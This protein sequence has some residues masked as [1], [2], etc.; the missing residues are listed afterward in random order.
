MSRMIGCLAFLLCHSI[1]VTSHA[2]TWSDVSGKFRVEAAFVGVVGNQVQLK[3]ADGRVINVPIAKLDAASI[4][5]A[6]RLHEQANA[7]VKPT[8][9]VAEEAAVATAESSAASLGQDPTIED[10]L[11]VLNRTRYADPAIFWDLLP[12]TYRRD[13]NELVRLFAKSCDAETWNAVVGL[14]RKVHRLFDEKED[15]IVGSPAVPAA[16]K[17]DVR[18]VLV[19]TGPVL[20][21]I[22]SSDLAERGAMQSFDG[23]QFFQ[24]Q[25]PE[26]KKQVIEFAEVVDKMQPDG[27]AAQKF[28]FTMQLVS[29]DGDTAVVNATSPTQQKEMRF[30]RIEDRWLP[31]ELLDRWS[32]D[33][34]A[35]KRALEALQSDEGREAMTGINQAISMVSGMLDP[36]L[37]AKTQEEFESG[38]MSL[39]VFVQFLK[40]STGAS[41]R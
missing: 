18:Q 2:E 26:L 31:E 27:F 29:V 22:L 34:T 21:A 40:A 32:T 24:S 3:K 10:T 15:R 4:A 7:S 28:D 33:M 25:Y 17:E 9:R 13:V 14:V 36:L 38:A 12:R 11:N 8:A 6:K 5:Q 35:A 30:R 19:V 1:L 23:D 39:A 16:Q 20:Q 37:E 41:E